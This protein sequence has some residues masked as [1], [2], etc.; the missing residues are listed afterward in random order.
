M[1]QSHLVPCAGSDKVPSSEQ[2]KPKLGITLGYL[3]DDSL[4]NLMWY[5]WVAAD[6]FPKP[7]NLQRQ[8]RAY[9][10]QS[11]IPCLLLAGPPKWQTSQ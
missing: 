6:D 9:L 11:W 5:Y 3:K 8:I 1:Q 4:T 7:M 2:C 10:C